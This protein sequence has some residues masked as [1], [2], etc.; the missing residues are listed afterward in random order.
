MLLDH[1]FEVTI[2]EGRERIGGRL[3]QVQ[4]SSG[5]L[6]DGGPNWIHGTEG[7]PIMELVK[8]TNTVTH[9]VWFPSLLAHW[10]SLAEFGMLTSTHPVGRTSPYLW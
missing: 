8:E 4:L 6:V 1:G 7:N 5:H 9:S 10:E 3:H 2:L